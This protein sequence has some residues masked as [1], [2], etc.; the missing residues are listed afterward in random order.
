MKY[1]KHKLVERTEKEALLLEIAWGKMAMGLGKAAL[2][3]L[4][5]GA[6]NK[7]KNRKKEKAGTGQEPA[8]AGLGLPAPKSSD[9][10]PQTNRPKSTS[11]PT[12]GK[13]A[14]NGKPA[15]TPRRSVGGALASG[16]AAYLS[17]VGKR[18]KQAERFAHPV[19]RAKSGDKLPA[20][21]TMDKKGRIVD[22]DGNFVRDKLRTTLR[23]KIAN[24]AGDVLSAY[25]GPLRQAM[26]G[27]H[28]T[29]S[30]PV[31]K[32]GKRRKPEDERDEVD[33]PEKGSSGAGARS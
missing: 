14:S 1:L 16:R 33:N 2:P 31:D 3:G 11:K 20:G 26:L 25:E 6:W 23:Q 7:F 19:A 28:D 30:H 9:L 27:F 29:G 12:S 8:A 21:Q 5:K 17:Y 13:P 24:R 4:A 22:K 15:G 10:T 18:K 32:G